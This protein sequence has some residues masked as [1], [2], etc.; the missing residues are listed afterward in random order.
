[1]LTLNVAFSCILNL[2][3]N[4]LPSVELFS[5]QSK[6]QALNPVRQ[7]KSFSDGGFLKEYLKQTAL[8][9]ITHKTS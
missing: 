3:H 6:Q 1:M 7:S 2:S 5:N 9:K 8:K 4:I